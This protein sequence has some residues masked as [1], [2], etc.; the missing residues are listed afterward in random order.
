[1]ST[2]TRPP[3]R[4]EP[5]RPRP[6]QGTPGVGAD[7]A[8]LPQADELPGVQTS[9]GLVPT[10]L[11][12]AKDL[13]HVRDLQPQD[14]EAVTALHRRCSPETLRLRYLHPSAQL[15]MLVE[16]MFSPR[17][18]RTLV[19][20]ATVAGQRRIVAV[21]HLVPT[22]TD[23]EAEV[24]FLVEDDWQGAGVGSA[25][26]S[27]VTELA[28]ACGW[29]RLH[30]DAAL[31]NDRMVHMFRTRGWSLDVADGTYALRLPLDGDDSTD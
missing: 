12:C 17:S 7:P 4:S 18:G 6:A 9:E 24:A 14:R 8:Q 28:R 5:S 19:A 2:R 15:D 26:L 30:A 1:M 13:V 20:E 16:W 23:G 31:D 22:N 11:L 27:L 29:A 10:W 3:R 21:A 25:L